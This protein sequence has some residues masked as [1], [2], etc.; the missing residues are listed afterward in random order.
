MAGADRGPDRRRPADLVNPV[1]EP[2]TVKK[3]VHVAVVGDSAALQAA[4]ATLVRA[5]DARP[6]HGADEDAG[7]IAWDVLADPEGNEFCC[8]PPQD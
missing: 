3:R 2:K 7:E 1:A 8:F 6:G 4:G 5:S